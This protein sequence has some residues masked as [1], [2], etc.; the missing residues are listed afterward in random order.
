MSTLNFEEIKAAQLIS[1]SGFDNAFTKLLGEDS[2]STHAEAFRILNE[3]YLKEFK[4]ARYKNFDSYR[5][6]RAKR[7]RS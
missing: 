2:I 1:V 5:V 4:Q 7:M 6:A 3:I